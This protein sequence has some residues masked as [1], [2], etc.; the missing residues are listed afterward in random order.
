MIT[1]ASEI[2]I[3]NKETQTKRMKANKT[4]LRN[5]TNMKIKANN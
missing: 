2:I 4:E 5:E 1:F 3:I